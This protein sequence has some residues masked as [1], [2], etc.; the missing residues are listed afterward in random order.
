MFLSHGTPVVRRSSITWRAWASQTPIG[1]ASGGI[2]HRDVTRVA[3]RAYGGSCWEDGDSAVQWNQWIP[4]LERP[5]VTTKP[6]SPVTQLL[7]AAGRGDAAAHEKLWS[8]IYDELHG[9]AQH[10]LDDEATGH[11]RQPTSLVHEAYLRLT[12]GQEVQWASR[13][14]FFTSA[15]LAMRRIRLDDARKRRS[16]KRGGGQSLGLL[17]EEAAVFDQDPTEVLAVDEALCRLEQENPRQAEVV[18]L[19]Y[20]AG[21][22]GD[23]TAD[24]LGISSRTVDNEWRVARAWLHRE[25][26]TGDATPDG[27][28]DQ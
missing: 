27:E 13:R 28:H 21:L 4:V 2:A 3:K 26:S 7:A 25:L 19:R 14:H 20:F 11:R 16:L 17:A 22:T 8:M 23:E 12:A 24:A 1:P 18:T 10:Q 6:P 5:K 9:L 15:A